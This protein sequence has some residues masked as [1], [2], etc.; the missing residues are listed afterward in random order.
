MSEFRVNV[1]ESQTV[2][3]PFGAKQVLINNVLPKW[4][5]L[6][7]GGTDIP[8]HKNCDIVVPPMSINLIPIPAGRDFAIGLSDALLTIGQQV[9]GTSAIVTFYSEPLPAGMGSI[10]LN[11][12]RMGQVDQRKFTAASSFTIA[13]PCTTV[14]IANYSP[15]WVYVKF[16]SLTIPTIATA[17][18]TLPP[19]SE[20]SLTCLPNTD[21]AF[22]LSDNLVTAGQQVPTG[23]NII[24]TFY[25]YPTPV[26]VG[27]ANL[28]P[29]RIGKSSQVSFTT[30]TL[31]T[32]TFP[33][34]QVHI[35]NFLKS[36]VYLAHDLGAIAAG[37][38]ELCLNPGFETAGGGG[39]DIW[40]NWVET[41]GAGGALADVGVPFVHSGVH[42]ARIT[43]GSIP[44]ATFI[45]Q[46]I[47][48]APGDI[49]YESF[50][51]RGDGTHQIE[52]Q[53]IDSTHFVG[54]VPETPTGV[55]GITYQQVT[56]SFQVPAGCNL[57]RIFFRGYDLS[58]VGYV[59]D[60]SVKL[61]NPI[62]TNAPVVI[63]PLSEKSINIPPSTILALGV[64]DQ[65]IQVTTNVPVTR[66]LATFYEY[67]T[68][69][70]VGAAPLS[71]GGFRYQAQIHNAAVVADG[72]SW[73]V[74]LSNFSTFRYSAYFTGFRAWMIT[75]FDSVTATLFPIASSALGFDTDKRVVVGQA[76]TKITFKIN[77]W[78]RYGVGGPALQLTDYLEAW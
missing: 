39:A 69:L 15:A 53:V 9:P 18:I 35:A 77:V 59:D 22:G 74:D 28:N 48:V 71:P 27:T 23:I 43:S 70:S 2:H 75:A 60:V 32:L 68:A 31:Q 36:W 12:S 26:S 4:V 61:A 55:T 56:F 6:R 57:I 62:A 49:V 64:S 58:G 42:A 20:K 46:D 63:P 16:G 44:N 33:A 47:V 52:Y 67:Y 38:P 14:H 24:T 25:E 45:Y 51:T 30:N 11:P 78:T 1:S 50:W 17:D 19:M 72:D 5:Y 40:A 65:T 7:L 41:I 66:A 21:F 54:L 10:D 76:G 37:N 29:T 13:F 8:T 3:T 34:T 73:Q